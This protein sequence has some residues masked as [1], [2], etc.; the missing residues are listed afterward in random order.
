MPEMSVEDWNRE[1][2]QIYR[3]LNEYLARQLLEANANDEAYHY[4][5][6]E[7]LNSQ[8]LEHLNQMYNNSDATSMYICAICKNYVHRIQNSSRVCCE[9]RGCIDIDLM[10]SI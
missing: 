9:R 6:Y 5:K 2:D 3:E 1:Y 7:Q 4:D 8:E 10:V